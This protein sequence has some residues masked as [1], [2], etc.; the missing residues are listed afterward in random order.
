M[1]GTTI[2]GRGSWYKSSVWTSFPDHAEREVWQL[3]LGVY[4]KRS[5]SISLITLRKESLSDNGAKK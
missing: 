3:F 4:Y 1:V 2:G 5:P